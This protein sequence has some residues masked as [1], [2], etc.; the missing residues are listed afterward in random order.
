[1]SSTLLISKPRLLDVQV[2]LGR[3][4]YYSAVG[5]LVNF[6]LATVVNAV[7]ALPDIPEVDSQRLSELS[8][9]LNALEGLFVEDHQ[10]VRLTAR[11]CP[12]D[13]EHSHFDKASFVVS[14]VPTWLKYSYLSELLVSCPDPSEFFIHA[15]LACFPGSINS[16]HIIS[17]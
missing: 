2:T 12:T 4:K 3:T 7:L 9:I 15:Q 11:D 1:M 8:R 13:N 6:A 5:H 10:E 14:Y 16:G 17:I